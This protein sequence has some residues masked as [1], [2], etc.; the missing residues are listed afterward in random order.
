M[1]RIRVDDNH[2]RQMRV[3]ARVLPRMVLVFGTLSILSTLAMILAGMMVAFVD[4]R[5]F[6]IDWW[7]ALSG[8]QLWSSLMWLTSVRMHW[9]GMDPWVRSSAWLAGVVSCA[10]AATNMIGALFWGLWSLDS[11]QLVTGV[12]CAMVL[13][14]VSVP[15]LLIRAG[16]QWKQQRAVGQHWKMYGSPYLHNVLPWW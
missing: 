13:N 8:V 10:S 14:F 11:Q 5:T 2:A 6:A 4:D 7:A 9:S 16:W 1:E 3:Y 12:T 15:M